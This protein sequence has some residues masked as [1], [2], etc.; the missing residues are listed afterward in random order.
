MFISKMMVFRVLKWLALALGIMVLIIVYAAN[1]TSEEDVKLAFTMATFF[2]LFAI[3][4]HLEQHK[5]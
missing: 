4:F 5:S 1:G 3:F 2:V